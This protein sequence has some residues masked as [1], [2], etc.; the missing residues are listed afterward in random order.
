MAVQLSGTLLTPLGEA[1][2]AAHIRFTAIT[3]EGTS[4][5]VGNNATHITGYDG[6]YTFS[7]QNGRY[8]LEIKYSD[9]YTESGVILVEESTPTPL[10]LLG[11]VQQTKEYTPPNLVEASAAWEQLFQSV[12]DND[13]W[14]K[15]NETQVRFENTLV[16]YDKAIHK[17][18]DALLAT[19]TETTTSGTSTVAN[20]SQAYENEFNQ[21]AAAKA[22]TVSTGDGGISLTSSQYTESDGTSKLAHKLD[23]GFSSASLTDDIELSEG[24]VAINTNMG[25]EGLT[26]SNTRNIEETDT[27]LTGTEESSFAINAYRDG[28]SHIGRLS[29]TKSVTYTDGETSPTVTY[30]Q[31]VTSGAVSATESTKVTEG[32]ATKKVTV[33]N[34]SVYSRDDAVTPVIEVNTVAREVTVNG[35][36]LLSNY[37]DLRGESG[38]S[39]DY[40]LQWGMDGDSTL[41]EDWFDEYQPTYYWQRSRKFKFIEGSLN[42]T[43]VFIEPWGTPIRLNAIDGTDGDEYWIKY[44]YAETST[45]TWVAATNYDEEIHEWRRYIYVIN[46]AYITDATSEL[47]GPHSGWF[48]EQI[49]GI[50]GDQGEVTQY[51]YRYSRNGGIADSEGSDPWHSNSVST[52][53]YRSSRLAYFRTVDDLPDEDV[54]AS[55]PYGYPYKTSVWGNAEQ[56]KPK[57]GVD[58]GDKFVAVTLYKRFTPPTG[59]A[60]ATPSELIG[61]M[62][63]DFDTSTLSPK[64][65][66]ADSLNG[67]S[68]LIP[69]GS[70]DIWVA[71]A[72]AKSRA[73]TDEIDNNQ[74]V[75]RSLVIQGKDGFEGTFTSYV[76]TV[77]DANIAPLTPQATT[78]TFN[79]SAETMPTSSDGTQWWDTPSLA[80]ANTPAEVTG[81]SYM[82]ESVCRYR[83]NDIDA[84]SD[85]PWEYLAY[86]NGEKW[87]API[88]NSLGGMYLEHQYAEAS[89]TFPTNDMPNDQ[90]N[91]SYWRRTRVVSVTG[92]GTLYSNWSDAEAYHPSPTLGVDFLDASSGKFTSYIFATGVGTTAPNAPSGGSFNGVTET[93]PNGWSDN[94]EYTTTGL[95]WVCVAVY[96]E[97]ITYDGVGGS[98]RTWK[99]NTD[100]YTSGWSAPAQY[101]GSDGADGLDGP[102]TSYVYKKTST[103][104]APAAPTKN[105][106]SFTGDPSTE[107]MP[108]GGWT[109]EP[110]VKV[111]GE[112]IWVSVMKY[113]MEAD[114]EWVSTSTYVQSNGGVWTTPVAYTGADG[115]SAM[116]LA[117]YKVAGSNVFSV[118][119][120]VGTETNGTMTY[121][122]DNHTLSG[123]PAGWTWGMTAENIEEGGRVFVSENVAIFPAGQSE[124]TIEQEDWSTP[125]TILSN[126]VSGENGYNQAI[127]H[128]YKRVTGTTVP[129]APTGTVTYEFA[130]KT[131]SGNLGTWTTSIP[132]ATV[133][134]A[135]LLY[136]ATASFVS[137]DGTDTV[138]AEGWDVNLYGTD[139][140]TVYTE[141]QYATTNASSSSAWHSDMG[142]DDYFRRER[143]VTV[144]GTGTTYGTWSTGE[145]FRLDGEDGYT[146]EKGT[147]YFD[148]NFI[149]YVYRLSVNEPSAPT[150]G[151]YNHNL[152]PELRETTPT[153][154]SDNPAYSATSKTWVSTATYT[155]S[156]VDGEV[157]FTR[158]ISSERPDGW[159]APKQYNGVN[160]DSIYKEYQYSISGTGSWHDDIADTDYY[161]R[162]RT[163]TVAY[164]GTSYGSWSSGVV[165]RK[166][167]YTP[168]KGVDY[169]DGVDGAFTSYVYRLSDV[170]L[171]PEGGSYNGTKETMPTNW[172]DNPV[173]SATVKTQVSSCR[174]TQVNGA[175]VRSTPW[176]ESVQY[177]G[178]DGA[179]GL[180]A[181][182]LTV[183]KTATT[184]PTNKPSNS[185]IYNWETGE[186]SPISGLNDWS[187]IPPDNTKNMYWCIATVA[188]VAGTKTTAVGEWSSPS[189]IASIGDEGEPGTP[190]EHGKGSFRKY[191]TNES[192]IPSAVSG[193]DA[194]VE[195]IANRDAQNGDLLNYYN[196]GVDT[197]KWFSRW[198]FRQ[199]GVWNETTQVVNGNSVI[200]GTLAAK[201]LIAKSITADLFEADIVFA[202]D[203]E[204]KT[205]TFIGADEDIPYDLKGAAASAQEE[206]IRV[207]GEDA[208]EKANAAKAAA[209]KVIEDELELAR[210]E[211][212]AYA[213]GVVTAEETRAIQDA[214]DKA[215]AAR[216]AAKEY[217]LEISRVNTN[218]VPYRYTNPIEGYLPDTRGGGNGSYEWITEPVN[219]D[220]SFVNSI[221]L[222]A[223]GLEY[224]VGLS[225]GF[226][227]YNIPIAANSRWIVSA[228]VYCEDTNSNLRYALYMRTSDNEWH[229]S[230]GYVTAGQWTRVYKV[231]D[232]TDN[233]SASALLRFD[234]DAGLSSGSAVMYFRNFML[235][236]VE[237]GVSTPSQY[238]SGLLYSE[239]TAAEERAISTAADAVAAKVYGN[240]TPVQISSSNYVENKSGW[241]I[242]AG[243]EA[244]FTDV[245]IRNGDVQLVGSKYMNITSSTPFGSMDFIEWTGPKAGKIASDGSVMTSEITATDAL[246]YLTDDGVFFIGGAIISGLLKNSWTTTKLGLESEEGA[247]GSLGS[248]IEINFSGEFQ[249]TSYKS[250]GTVGN[251]T[252]SFQAVLER[253]LSSTGNYS[254]VATLNGTGEW[255]VK[256]E[257]TEYV[258]D[259]YAVGGLTYTDV[260]RVEDT[261]YYR[262]RW[263]SLESG[264]VTLT[265]QN[266]SFI[267]QEG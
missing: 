11:L 119:A 4:N 140:G 204:A 105:T 130:T 123:V 37:E 68:Q 58:Y 77:T 35:Q 171:T 144:L 95:T 174:Y 41:D 28:I 219:G 75:Y 19:G 14:N 241:A 73:T 122:A 87:S 72:T 85:D 138:G 2:S 145:R 185:L 196:D 182:T 209:E 104:V 84:A 31:E 233:D 267:S 146:P 253:K 99:R 38:W 114:D 191:L 215:N 98:T 226:G 57:E 236:R 245:K 255:S 158:V 124:V 234:F 67:W 201:A 142:S 148:G 22:T 250:T 101:L 198:F 159:S 260:L 50:N 231:V 157:V 150:G 161:R 225:S 64:D 51:Q 187:A 116:P 80:T 132:S 156:I 258:G 91:T 247:F 216:D 160:G 206:A 259:A 53:Y 10:T 90:S 34:F 44:E 16:N 170:S 232:L 86:Q 240:Q 1:C 26:F 36:F 52:D 243:G 40:D 46:G 109:D 153:G 71:V 12:L 227:N 15:Q 197:T 107:V 149:S 29:E 131:L 117:L 17:D 167:G 151:S 24:S 220:S 223:T 173:Y 141:F 96:E 47:Y 89:D 202:G 61:T 162:E 121:N 190:G 237:D 59:N 106:G 136:V 205:L 120:P 213:D 155:Q 194:H 18:G 102:Y 254:T 112:Y 188:A 177:L 248:L 261:R 230:I 168:E 23:V 249:G 265:K 45:G 229:T 83:Q 139:S 88:S 110:P 252:A 6:G 74:W 222:T 244:E 115:L 133:G 239:I 143:T 25:V 82:W 175:W 169:F 65:S 63:W 137:Q 33:D 108:S 56:I 62:V 30:G 20:Q 154:W 118:D 42:E 79:G 126:G 184:T 8:L 128:V 94:P 164:T 152:A 214:T 266:L 178:Q 69:D 27:T 21:K 125:T 147:D 172:Q 186:V 48:I 103:N 129:S 203:I 179:S 32:T 9:E 5:L 127:V 180:Q 66:E 111:S 163:V 262:I 235:E 228:D 200:D 251:G 55:W 54:P 13:E 257:G 60:S 43:K 242:T 221:K 210:I 181:I 81:D 199:S 193:K 93:I 165:F 135:T 3:A 195:A 39:Y 76:Y 212:E 7:L 211:S 97:T 238:V 217:A 256:K 263:V 218:I 264:T 183:Y 192:S 166:D 49:K 78:G 92:S 189:I 134:T 224:Y 70:D 207:A 100:T 176:S 208:T 113:V 246:Q